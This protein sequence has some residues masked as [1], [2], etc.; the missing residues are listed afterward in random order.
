MVKQGGNPMDQRAGIMKK[1]ELL[2]LCTRQIQIVLYLKR[3][4]N[5]RKQL[6]IQKQ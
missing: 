2:A 6:S 1:Q 3:F 4:K 5:A